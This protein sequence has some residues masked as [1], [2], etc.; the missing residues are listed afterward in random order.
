MAPINDQ[1]P[2]AARVLAEQLCVGA[3]GGVMGDPRLHRQ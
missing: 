1:G 3:S 2:E